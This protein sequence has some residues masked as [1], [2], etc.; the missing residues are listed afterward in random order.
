MK[1]VGQIFREKLADDLK[2][3]IEKNSNVFVLTYSDL[4]SLQIS[5]LRKSLK[6]A[7]ADVFVSKNRIAQIALKNAEQTELAEKVSGQT[8]FIWSNADSSAVSKVLVKFEKDSKKAVI[9]GGILDGVYL[10]NVDVKRL[11]DL[12]SREVLLAML[13]GII[14]ITVLTSFLAF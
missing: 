3:G 2:Q 6:Q 4:S 7:G 10:K 1:R 14:V 11:S 5:N 9:Q 13:L 12:P 8:A